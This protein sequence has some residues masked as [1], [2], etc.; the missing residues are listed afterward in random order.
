MGEYDYLIPAWLR[1]TPLGAVWEEAYIQTGDGN[2]AL[3]AVRADDLYETVFAGNKRDDGTVRYNEND[4]VSTMESY[5][6]SIEAIGLNSQLFQD[7][8]VQLIEGDVDADEFWIERVKP[9]YDRV[10]NNTDAVRA[11]YAAAFQI[12]LTDEAILASVLDPEGVGQAVLDKTIS[13][14]EIRGEY[15]GR[16]NNID[17]IETDYFTELHKYGVDQD[18]ARRFF[19]NADTMLPVLG[20]LAARHDDPDDEFDLDEFTQASVYEDPF[21]RSRIRRLMAQERSTFQQASSQIDLV[22]NRITGA[23]GLEER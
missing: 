1:G 3:L 15:S 5:A 19:A 8:F 22:R 12:S 16:W 13:M 23:S 18:Q 2:A 7:K 6:D 10:M 14:S 4:Y 21:Q 20:V 9:V 17:Q 11:E